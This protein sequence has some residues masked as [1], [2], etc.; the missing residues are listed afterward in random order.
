MSTKLIT[1]F[2]ATGNQGGS[3]AKSLVQ[4]P[5]FSVRGITRNPDSA[6]SHELISRGIE[7]IKANGFNADE[8]TAAFEGSWGAFVNINSDDNVFPRPKGL[9]FGY[10]KMTLQV[11]ADPNAATEFDLG[12]IIVGAAAR[13]GVRHLVFSSGPPCTEMTGGQVR[14]KAMDSKVSCKIT[15]N[16]ALTRQQ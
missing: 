2:G 7:M 8:M 12:K 4:N 1:I 5:G 3:V 16:Y 11:F 9:V 15:V 13:A 10:A 6:A 14:M